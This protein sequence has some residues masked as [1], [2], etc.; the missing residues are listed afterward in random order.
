M[1]ICVT[2]IIPL[3]I[4]LKRETLRL[5]KSMYMQHVLQ[6]SH[7]KKTAQCL[8]ITAQLTKL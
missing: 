8:Y 5:K 1:Q 3:T 6:S 4:W 2:F 7:T